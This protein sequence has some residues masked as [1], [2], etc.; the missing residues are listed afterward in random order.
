M[1]VEAESNGGAFHGDGA[2]LLLVEIVHEAEAAGELGVEEAAAG[3]GDQVVGESR[4]AVVDVGQYADVSDFSGLG[5]GHRF[6]YDLILLN[7]GEKKF[8]FLKECLDRLRMFAEVDDDG[9]YFFFIG[10]VSEVSVFAG[11]FRYQN[12]V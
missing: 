9:D 1:V 6:Q 3:G 2:P 5:I 7:D 4:L 11:N 8:G 10:R 12:I